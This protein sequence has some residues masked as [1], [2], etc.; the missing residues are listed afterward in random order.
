MHDSTLKAGR[1]KKVF[2]SGKG[3]LNKSSNQAEVS[4]K[5][6]IWVKNTRSKVQLQQEAHKVLK[7]TGKLRRD[8]TV[9]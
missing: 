9:V 8:V 4:K 2:T 5:G 3:S 1:F 6:K 7:P